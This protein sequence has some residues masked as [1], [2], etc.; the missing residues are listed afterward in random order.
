MDTNGNV[1]VITGT[2]P[3]VVGPLVPVNHA[4]TT[5]PVNSNH[6]TYVVTLKWALPFPDTNYT[7]TCSALYAFGPSGG[8]WALQITS[9]SQTSLQVGVGL[10]P[11]QAPSV[12][13]H[14]IG[15]HD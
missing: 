15:V 3:Q 9:I 5:V 14:C 6:D 10:Y 11:S 7:A 12:T 13:L 2:S 1:N 8:V 4:R